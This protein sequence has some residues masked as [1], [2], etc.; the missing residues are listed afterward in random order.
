MACYEEEIFGPVMNIVRMDN[1]QNAID[2]INSNKWGNGSS[3]FTKN[4]HTARKF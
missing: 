3:I 1:L 4:G 2:F